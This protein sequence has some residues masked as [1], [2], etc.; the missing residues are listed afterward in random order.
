MDEM[1]GVLDLAIE[2]FGL[3]A[4]QDVSDYYS[5]REGDKE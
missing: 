1:V 4:R 5:S 3:E 2:E